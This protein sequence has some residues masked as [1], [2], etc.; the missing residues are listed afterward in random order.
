ATPTPAAPPTP[1]PPVA[2]EMPSPAPAPST[3]AVPPP[4]PGVPTQPT[5]PAPTPAVAATPPEA[6]T[7][8]EAPQPAH[9]D[10][11]DILARLGAETAEQA[12]DPV[13]REPTGVAAPPPPA[14]AGKLTDPRDL[15]RPSTA[16][17]IVIEVG[18]GIEFDPSFASFGQRAVGA[19]VDTLVVSLAALPGLLILLLGDGLVAAL[20][21]VTVALFGFIAV[22]VLGARALATSGK[23]VGNRVAGTTVVDAINGS[24]IDQGRGALRMLGRHVIS[25]I[26]L[27]GYVIAFVDSQRRTFHDRL[28]GTVVT[29]RQREVWTADD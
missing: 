20:L 15:T 22:V 9:D 27:F 19:V 11:D 3:P 23:W 6:P 5:T 25:P 7:P 24:Y 2:S 16:S 29:R 17:D 1:A 8:V 13:G 26:L 12:N 28:A 18:A 14:I 10:L 4:P 21:G